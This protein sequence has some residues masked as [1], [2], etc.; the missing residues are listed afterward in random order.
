MWLYRRHLYLILFTLAGGCG[1]SPLYNT[2]KESYIIKAFSQINVLPIKNRTGQLFSNEIKRLLDPQGKTKNPIYN[3]KVN[4]SE[5]NSSLGVKKSAIA[6]RGNLSITATYS[7]QSIKGLPIID[8][9][10]NKITVSYNKFNSAWATLVAEED[11]RTRGIRALTQELRH[12][13]GVVLKNHKG[14]I[15]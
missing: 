12:H 7:L 1:F 15:Y 4:L 13:L 8:N 2:G 9:S 5:V 3:L 6:T 10:V 14:G 11:A